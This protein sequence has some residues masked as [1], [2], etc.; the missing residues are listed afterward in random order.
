SYRQVPDGIDFLLVRAKL[1][2]SVESPGDAV[3]YFDSVLRDKRYTNEA[4][5][6]YGLVNALLRYRNH[7]RADKELVLLYEALQSG[8]KSE[9][10][11][12]HHLGATIRIARKVSRSSPMIET[13][14]ARVKLAGGQ[15][16]EALDIYQA[17]LRIYPQHR[18]LIYEYAEALLRNDSADIALKFVSQQLQFTP[19]DTRLYRLQAQSYS[20]L[21]DSM[22]QHRAQA[23]I[24]MQQGNFPAAVEQLQIALK[25]NE[26]DF[27]QMS[28]LEARLKE[29]RALAAADKKDKSGW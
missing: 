9:S 25:S 19:N 14:A 3:E 24:Y 16:A 1:R 17:A 2:A 18:A 7:V 6:R 15:T 27:Y 29:F 10:V 23:E 21:G 26:G 8:S 12:N 5:E 22:S 20:A 13:L 28:S 11:E 4:V